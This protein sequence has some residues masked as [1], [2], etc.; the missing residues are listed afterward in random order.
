MT[1]SDTSSALE[2]KITD[3][4]AAWTGQ[5]IDLGGR[6]TLLYYRDLKSGTL[7]LEGADEVA[8][9]ELLGS[10]TVRLSNLFAPQDLG[11]AARRARTVRAKAA[12]NFEERGLQ[13]LFLAWGM[14]TWTNPAWDRHPGRPG[15]TAPGPPVLP[16]AAPRRTS[17]SRYPASG[18]STRPCSTCSASTTTYGSTPTGCSDLLDPRLIHPMPPTVFDRLTKEAA[19]VPGFGVTPRVVLATSP[20]PSCPWSRTSR[21]RPGLARCQNPS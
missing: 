19:E 8:T 4:V 16:E 10:R 12:E 11:A 9:E 14:A 21:R 7:A 13:T 1:T 5:L 6:N 3:A 15:A 17:T 2:S 20:T 18:R